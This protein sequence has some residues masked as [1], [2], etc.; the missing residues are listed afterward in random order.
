MVSPPETEDTPRTWF[1]R[2]RRPILLLLLWLALAG[3]FWARFRGELVAAVG[4]LPELRF[5]V[6]GALCLFAA[7]TVVAANGWRTLLRSALPADC[8]TPSLHRLV[9]IRV[10]AQALNFI[11][12]T[13][14][15]A[16]ESLRALSAADD[17]DAVRG[18]VAAI[19]LDN[20]A[21]AVAGLTMSAAAVPLLLVAAR[22]PWQ[23]GILAG[24]LL[25]VLGIG[26]ERVPFSIARPLLRLLGSG[27]RLAGVLGILAEKRDLR[28]A[29]RRAVAWHLLERA[30]SVG[31]V[32]VVMVALG[33]GATLADSTAIASVFVLVSFAV[34]FVPAQLG[35]AEI[36]VVMA[37]MSLGISPEVGIAIA[38]VRRSRQLLVCVLGL[39]LLLRARFAGGMQPGWSNHREASRRGGLP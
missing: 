39:L 17:R 13:A 29:H 15:L 37:C 38:L 21:M 34:F 28:P 32:H 31:E 6:L 4:L 2:A 22:E 27:S 33:V 19:V 3:V 23:V 14:G 26:L 20:V 11:L 12:P 16:G 9:M 25:V 18:S 36:A 5:A 30:I 35:V 24:A 7:W 1:S 8:V 10:Q